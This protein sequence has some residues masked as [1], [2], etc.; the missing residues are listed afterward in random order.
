MRADGE[1]FTPRPHRRTLRGR[2]YTA[3]Q[4]LRGFPLDRFARELAAAEA[5]PPAE[6]DR[7]N[8][9]LLEA[10]LAFA[11][12]EVPLYQGG[13]WAAVQA[14]PAAGLAPWPVIDRSVL[15]E[16]YDELRVRSPGG[17]ALIHHTSGSTGA[18]VKVKLSR[19]AETWG[20][21]HRYRGLLWHRL[22]IGVRAMRLSHAP[23]PLRDFLLNQGCFR[24]LGEPGAV[25][26][27]FAYLRKRRPL[28][29]TG[30]PSKLF[31]LARGLRERGHQGPLAP[32]ARVGGEQMFPFQRAAIERHLC[33]RAIDS[34][35]C[36][37]IGAIAGECE[38]GSMHVFAD[39]VHV[40]IFN[41][42]A[43]ADTGAFGDVVVTALRNRAMPLVRYRVGDRAR[44]LPDRCRCGLPHPVIADLQARAVDSF[45]AADGTRHHASELVVRLDAIYASPEAD[46]IRQIQ[47]EQLDGSGWRVWL[48][49]RIPAQVPAALEDRLANLVHAVAGAGSRVECRTADDLPRVRGKFRYYRLGTGA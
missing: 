28:L 14:A 19:E 36:T 16:H 47:F 15:L 45:T 13:A 38:A 48:E 27:A 9:A 44:L 17:A 10:A 4:G 24:N 34:Y 49:R 22:P 8:A 29:V 39:H 33:A 12:R 5:L 20:W 18:S 26:A 35:G 43:P 42:D 41:G 37:E 2:L 25:D 31:Y 3:L 1:R 21:A 40:E 6:F 23:R 32:F 11:R 30:S 46:G 7:R